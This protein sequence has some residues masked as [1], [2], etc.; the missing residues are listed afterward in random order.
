M[1][2]ELTCVDYHESSLERLKESVQALAADADVQL[3]I[4]PEFMC[5]V[6]ELAL[7]FDHWFEVGRQFLTPD[8]ISVLEPILAQLGEM[9]GPEGPWAEEDLATDPRWEDIRAKAAHALDILGWPHD[10]P[11]P[12]SDVV[13]PFPR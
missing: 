11:P 3:S 5:R 12:S 4:Y 8:Q 6:D 1:G 7:D 2:C 9:S 10:P 13:V